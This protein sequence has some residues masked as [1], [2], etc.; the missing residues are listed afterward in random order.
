MRI[1]AKTLDEVRNKYNVLDR[2]VR[3]T[4]KWLAMN[5]VPMCD[6]FIDHE[7]KLELAEEAKRKKNEE[8]KL[9]YLT[10]VYRTAVTKRGGKELEKIEAKTHYRVE[11]Y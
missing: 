4:R 2:N 6:F 7:R 3:E 5:E 11:K 10:G 1:D 8:S 9:D